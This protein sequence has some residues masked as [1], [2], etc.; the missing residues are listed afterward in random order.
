MTICLPVTIPVRTTAPTFVQEPVTLDEAKR[1]CDIAD[2]NNGFDAAIR[3]WIVLAR[4]LVEKDASIACFT[5]EYKF[6]KTLWREQSNWGDWFELNLKPITAIGSI[7]YVATDGDTDTWSSSE[8]SLD[9]FTIAPIVKLSYGESWPTL[10]GDINGITVT[11]TA[12]YAS[13]AVIP[14][15]IKHACKLLIRHWFDNPGIVG[16]V[17]PEIELTYDAL[18]NSIKRHTY[19]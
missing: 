2:G 17:G 7:T 6:K 19:S 3:D 1:Q 11:V 10:R 4:E 15:R 12:G 16:Q 13:V 9:T 18:I 8:Y 14:Q 5:G